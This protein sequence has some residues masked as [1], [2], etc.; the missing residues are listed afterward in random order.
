MM[1]YQGYVGRVE[2]DAGSDTFH[3]EVVGT[4]D[5]ITFEGRSVE[6][7]HQA[8]RDSVD[9]YL[10][11]CREAGKSPDRPFSGQFVVRLDPELHRTMATL[12]ALSGRSLNAWVIDALTAAADSAG[13]RPGAGQSKM[14][15]PPRSKPSAARRRPRESR[16]A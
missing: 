13:D 3:G 8:L 15:K 10:E 5:V 11:V 16:P 6:E 12:A 7:L 2:Y 4:R 1:E 9:T 14:G